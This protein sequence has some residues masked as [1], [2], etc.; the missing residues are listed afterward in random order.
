MRLVVASIP[1]FLGASIRFLLAGGIPMLALRLRGERAP[2]ALEWRHALVSGLLLFCTGN[3]L[4]MWIEQSLPS[5]LTA[6]LIG[7][8]PVWFVLFDWL[9]PDG[10][11][12]TALTL[13]GLGLG[14]LGVFIL[15]DP[16]QPADDA[17]PL[18]PLC[19]LLLGCLTWV[20]GSLYTKHH[21]HHPSVWMHSAQNMLVGGTAL[22]VLAALN[23]ELSRLAQVRAS[24]T[25]VAALVYLITMG[26]WVGFGAYAWLLPRVPPSKL[27]TYAY[28]NPVIAVL[29]GT[30]VLDEPF[31]LRTGLAALAIFAAVAC[32]QAAPKPS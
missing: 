2:T 7:I 14:T 15:A 31:T 25:S 22:M 19:V 9:R 18:F 1:P 11:R 28:V 23:G 4:V 10:A 5:G 8:S 21:P 32:V 24:A 12:P 30:L 6:L 26:S 16:R 27:S 3:G 17:L 29:L 20:G 13:F